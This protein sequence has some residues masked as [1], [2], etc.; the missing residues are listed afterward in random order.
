M[1]KFAIFQ[2]KKPLK[3]ELFKP[4]FMEMYPKLVRYAT[5]L[6]NDVDEAKDIVGDVMERAWN[7]FDKLDE[8]TRSAWFYTAVRNGCLNRMKHLNVEMQH[9]E[10]VIH[11]TRADVDNNYMEHERLLQK[12]ERIAEELS[13]PTCTI[14]RL[15]YW[16]KMTYKYVANRLGISPD[17]VKKHISKA[18]RILRESMKGDNQ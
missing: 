9:I 13:E 2:P 18:L 6:M 7:E 16:Q 5:Q 14:L 10:A 17:T 3:E 8:S 4:V 15:C 11:A 1:I 12:A